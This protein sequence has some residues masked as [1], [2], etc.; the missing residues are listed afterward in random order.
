M[1]VEACSWKDTTCQIPGIGFS[2]LTA[3]FYP[4]PGNSDYG[5]TVIN[6]ANTSPVNYGPFLSQNH[7]SPIVIDLDGCNSDASF[8]DAN[9][10]VY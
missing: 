1:S 5:Y 8:T 10:G 4:H 6:T 3:Y 9:H 7:P 2:G